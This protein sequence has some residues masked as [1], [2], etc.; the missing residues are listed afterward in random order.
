MTIMLDVTDLETQ[1]AC[2]RRLL[3]TAS[4]GSSDWLLG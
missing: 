3:V 4:S 2:G 1:S